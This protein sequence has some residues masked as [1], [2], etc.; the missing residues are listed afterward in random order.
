MEKIRNWIIRQRDR[1]SASYSR[2]GRPGEEE[3]DSRPPPTSILVAPFNENSAEF[4]FFNY[5]HVQKATMAFACFGMSMV[6]LLFISS[7]FEFD[8]YHHQRGVDVGALLGLFFYLALGVLIHYYVLY[9]IKKQNSL[10]LLPFILV[11]SI[12]CTGELFL[13]FALVFKVMDPQT[14]VGH[15]TMHTPLVSMLIVVIITII[16]QAMMLQSVLKCREFLS[17]KA[18]HE[19]ELKVA[20]KSRKENPSIQIVVADSQQTAPT[21]GHVV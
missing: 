9:G 6:I 16:V 15:T 14:A 4:M 11:Y 7:F 2:F 8:W 20:E 19:M 3:D 17:L 18:I 12:I 1:T 13:F 21:N 5:W 10:Y